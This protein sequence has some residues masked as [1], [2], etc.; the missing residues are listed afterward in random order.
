M[1]ILKVIEVLA[2]SEKSWEDAAQKAVKE[3]SR[4]VRNIRSLYVENM[5]AVVEPGGLKYR[6][7]AKISF[8]VDPDHRPGSRVR[9]AAAVVDGEQERSAY[10]ER[11][12]Q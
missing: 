10:A 2:Q 9:R 7:D 1:A 4:S 11:T 5:Q 12:G 8:E 6:L 3:A